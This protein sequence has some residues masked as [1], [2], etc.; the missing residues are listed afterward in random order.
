[1]EPAFK[2]VPAH[3]TDAP[4][5]AHVNYTSWHESYRN[6]ISNRFL[7]SLTIDNYEKRWNYILNNQTDKTFVHVVKNPASE[8]IGYCTGGPVRERFN[9]FEGEIY[10]LYLLQ[11]YHGKGIGGTL[12]NKAVMQLNNNGHKSFCLFVLKQNPTIQFYRHYQPHHEHTAIVKI[13]EDEYEDI[14]LGWNHYNRF[15]IG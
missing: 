13:G 1:M 15:I 7:D 12:F 6:I 4:G 10:A 2:I 11:Q 5:I 8:I 9:H 14:G 3:I